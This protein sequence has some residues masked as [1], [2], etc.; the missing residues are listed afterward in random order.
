MDQVISLINEVNT[1]VIFVNLCGDVN[2]QMYDAFTQVIDSSITFDRDTNVVLVLEIAESHGGQVC[3]VVRMQQ[4]LNLMRMFFNNK[5][6]VATIGIGYLH[7]SATLIH[8]LG[9][10][11]N[12]QNY[13][14]AIRA[15][16][17]FLQN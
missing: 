2:S 1:R 16:V 12:I 8:R 5:L 7:S 13:L 15:V 4:Y 6:T 10:M 11:R 3:Q 17:S 9:D 14:T